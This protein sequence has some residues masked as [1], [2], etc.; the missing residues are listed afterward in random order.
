MHSTNF[1]LQLRQI[2]NEKDCQ[3]VISSL[4]QDPLIWS[5]FNNLEFAKYSICFIGNNVKK[6]NPGILA[7]L[8]LFPEG[9]PELIN[10]IL[11]GPLAPDL[12]QKAILQFEQVLL[13]RQQP[14]TLEQAALSALALK[15]R[16]RLRGTWQGIRDELS[17][18]SHEIPNST[19]LIWATTIACVYNLVSEPTEF[20]RALIP[21]RNSDVSKD[22]IGLIV[23]AI[24]SSPLTDFDQVQEFVKL[25]QDYPIEI[26]LQILKQ[27]E[28]RGRTELVHKL[29]IAFLETERIDT[30]YLNSLTIASNNEVTEDTDLPSLKDPLTFDEPLRAIEI[31]RHL[32]SL[33]LFAA[34]PENAEKMLNRAND[35][36]KRWEARLSSQL[37][38][39]TQ[40]N[41]DPEAAIRAW[42]K[43]LDLAPE[44]KTI[45]LQIANTMMMADHWE[46]ANELLAALSDDSQSKYTQVKFAVRS[47]ET[48]K[49]RT[50]AK[51]IPIHEFLN[52][53]FSGNNEDLDQINLAPLPGEVVSTLLGLGLV[54]EA[55]AFTHDLVS[56]RS[57]DRDLLESTIKGYL[58]LNSAEDAIETSLV[59][60]LLHPEEIKFHKYLASA[61]ESGNDFQKA[62]IERQ[63]ILEILP[64]PE[65]EDH[66]AFASVAIKLGQPDITLSTAQNVL[67]SDPENGVAHKLI[68]L[69]LLEK[70]DKLGAID[71]FSQAI[72]FSPEQSDAW[73]A[74][75]NTYCEIGDLQKN[76]ETLREASHAVPQSSEILFALAKACL[77]SGSPSEGLPALREAFSLDDH[78]A[79]IGLLLGNTL[80]DLGHF[81]EADQV[82]Q[83]AR[84]ANPRNPELA[85]LHSQIYILLG[86]KNSALKALLI[87]S[88]NHSL[89]ADSAILL[90]QTAK[91]IRG[92]KAAYLNMDGTQNR[93]ESSMI[94]DLDP[95]LIVMALRAVVENDPNNFEA[96]LLLGDSLLDAA[97]Y[98]DAYDVFSELS[99][100]SK[101]QVL[102]WSDRVQ[103]GLG[104][105]ALQTNQVDMAVTLLQEAAMAYPDNIEIHHALAEALQTASLD[106]E[107]IIAARE[108]LL[109]APDD[110]HN[111][112][113]FAKKATDLNS[114][115]EAVD[116][117]EQA[118]QIEPERADLVLR[119][120]QIHIEND[121]VPAAKRYLSRLFTIPNTSPKEYRLAAQSLEDIDEFSSAITFLETVE[122]LNPESSWD[123]YSEMANTYENVGKYAKALEK[124]QKAKEIQ[125]EEICL[126]VS[127]SDLLA[128][129]DQNFDAITCLEDTL[130]IIQKSASESLESQQIQTKQILN[131]VLYK[132]GHK[133]ITLAQIHL[134]L[135]KLLRATGEFSKALEQAKVAFALDPEAIQIRTLTAELAYSLIEDDFAYQI[136][137]WEKLVQVEKGKEKSQNLFD[138]DMRISLLSIL[139]DLATERGETDLASKAISNGFSLSP[140]HPRLLALQARMAY[141]RGEIEEADQILQETLF[142]GSPLEKKF[143]GD[144]LPENINDVWTTLS[145]AEAALEL[146]YW[147][148]ALTGFKKAAQQDPQLP[149]THL[150]FAR[151]IVI[152][153]EAQDY[154]KTLKITAHAPDQVV[155]REDFENEIIS[156]SEL[157]DHPSVNHW[158]L[159]GQVCFQPNQKTLT[160]LAR[161]ASS[162][163][164]ISAMIIGYQKNNDFSEVKEWAQ[165]AIENSNVMFKLALSLL[166][167]EPATSKQIM[168]KLTS[169]N[170]R[171]PRYSA[172]MA[173]LIQ[174]SPEESLYWIE[175]ASKIWPEETEWHRF[176]ANLYH[177]LGNPIL[178]LTHR[179][180]IVK[181]NPTNILDQITLGKSHIDCGD[182]NQAL[183]ILEG[184]NR[185]DT[186]NVEVWKLMATAQSK[187]GNSIEAKSSIEH[188][189]ALNPVDH[190]ALVFSGQLELSLNQVE[191]ALHRADT[192]LAGNHLDIDG[193][194]LY[195]QSMR[196]K[197][198]SADALLAID[199]A[200]STL[201]NPFPLLLERAHLI[202]QLHGNQELLPDLI[203]LSKSHPESAEVSILLA[204]TYSE[205]G[206]YEEAEQT[207]QTALKLS[208]DDPSM[209]L[210]L[211]HIQRAKGQLDQ[212]IQ[213]L[214]EAIRYSPAQVDAYIELGKTYQER[215]D[216]HRALRI[217]RQATQVAPEDFRP[218]Y[219]AGLVLRESKDYVGAESMF[220]RAA[221]LA[222]E[223]VNV[224]RQLG[225]II[226]L[227]LVHNPQLITVGHE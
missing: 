224:K 28:N 221:R 209:H 80:Y 16:F 19:Y 226:T 65:P 150:R 11:T 147:N 191:K 140:N 204:T 164:D 188:A 64:T 129:L 168:Q 122:I 119:L 145:L 130:D 54:P 9:T 206:Q 44:S 225:A 87:S 149:R 4:R 93:D 90:A 220:R 58:Q 24:L 143:A 117:L 30:F 135:A 218:F 176:A 27:L 18:K 214:D 15:E 20:L 126:G 167:E 133:E 66:L 186:E 136:C 61:F 179:Q 200:L 184:T 34:E 155:L 49:A 1:L 174:D 10:S 78:S 123:F 96:Q 17:I 202:K 162:P 211:G 38:L 201:N 32:A 151:A 139:N 189:L 37:A 107:A 223:N 213:H 146:G 8:S 98:Q 131:P 207:A 132:Q 227:N 198:L 46:E 22:F 173:F 89:D 192:I 104:K 53:S 178:E 127:Q 63:S 85:F 166:D 195:T 212:S 196:K 7:V 36:I 75:S 141:K 35:T 102:A 67:Q 112:I 57:N 199:Q 25:V 193:L 208:P 180:I 170:P 95:M 12:R 160:D 100:N 215:R 175:N 152:A 113:W 114:L 52:N 51:S 60:T 77:K 118:I 115:P 109:I 142:S 71:H 165:K 205:L 13:T 74:L 203:A 41:Q 158:K 42:K 69:A 171:E 108:A 116:A 5:E 111:L 48:E 103:L 68:G 157:F 3:V 138:S 128:K 183:Q 222:P 45:Q 121:N 216:N 99:E 29:A 163:D 88:E 156:I 161:I 181:L 47:G 73:L 148:A 144:E 23:H 40:T 72:S 50:L 120:S 159:R 83:K 91:E 43:A 56:N 79:A 185:Q 105:S 84:N 33:F 110:I 172:A 190:E 187:L 210:L 182:F 154:C 62:F 81:E 86:D 21:L 169:T 59:G 76:L 217:F 134:R 26:H 219:Q 101:A 153:A 94:D 197:G 125:P 6:W 194:V 82:L 137:N 177:Q 92:E 106:Q 14:V 39:I 55:V 97:H 70:K 124:N 2:L 31:L